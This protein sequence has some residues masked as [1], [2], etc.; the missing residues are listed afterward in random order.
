MQQ[1]DRGRGITPRRGT[2]AGRSKASSRVEPGQVEKRRESQPGGFD[3]GEL[4]EARRPE[5]SE[6]FGGRRDIESADEPQ[7]GHERRHQERDQTEVEPSRP[8]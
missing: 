8:A 1:P 6:D 5:S 2:R 3:A 4:A 7:E